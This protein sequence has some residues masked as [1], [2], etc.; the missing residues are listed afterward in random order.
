MLI[1]NSPMGY[2]PVLPMRKHN[3]G[4]YITC[5]KAPGPEDSRVPVPSLCLAHLPIS[6]TT[7]P[8]R[9]WIKFTVI[10]II[11]GLP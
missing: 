5:P 6:L 11:W 3:L 9:F 2:L 1:F 7:K 4:S 10:Q 8:H